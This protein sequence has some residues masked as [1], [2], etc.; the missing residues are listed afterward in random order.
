MKKILIVEDHFMVRISLKIMLN[1]L[2]GQAIPFEAERFEDALELAASHQ[3]ELIILDIDIPGGKGTA[4]I[5]LL[6]Q[7]QPGVVIL[8][9]SAADEEKHALNYI[10]EGANGYLSKSAPKDEAMTAIA[11]VLKRNKY[12]SQTVQ[13]QL[14][15]GVHKGNRTGNRALIV[16]HL[17]SREYEVM[18]LLLEGKWVKEIAASLDL[19]ANTISTYKAR[20]FE[21]MEVTNLFEL[22]KKVNPP[23]ET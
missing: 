19:R 18:Q 23:E 13:Q 8:V 3:F 5:D 10:A 4:M 15:D 2:F 21:K 1:E 14:L 12:V 22:F 20:I 6:R 7:R 11:T 17:S 9:C 16:K